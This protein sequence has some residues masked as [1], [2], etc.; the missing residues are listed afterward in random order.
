MPQSAPVRF[1]AWATW[2]A[3]DPA[4]W[5]PRGYVV[6]NADLRGWGAS[7]G[8]GELLNMRQEGE[9]CH[10]LIEWAARQPWSNGRV[11][12][13]GVSYLAISQWSAAATRP[14]H[15]AA[16]CP[17]EGFTDT[18]R[19]FA[20]PG[21][22]R[23][24]GFVVIWTRMAKLRARNR[25]QATADLRDQQLARPE[26]DDWWASRA[27]DVD[28]IDA[29]A[30]VCGSFSDHNLHTDG[31]FRGF[32]RIG[33]AQKWLY[34]HRG[35]KWATFYSDDALTAQTRFFDHFLA[36]ADNG[37]TDQ[38]PVRLEVRADADTITAVRGEQQWPPAATR[39]Q[40]WHLDPGTGVLADAGPRRAGVSSFDTRRGRVTLVRRFTADTEVVGPM[41][42]RLVVEARECAD[43]YLFAGVRKLRDGRPVA[44]E[45]AYGFR[46]SLVT[47]GMR[48]AS[49]RHTEETAE[50][51]RPG[52]V[53]GLDIELHPSAT[54]F[55]AD[56]ELQL[57]IRGRWF[58]GRFPLTSQFPAYY[59]KSPRGRCLL[60]TGPDAAAYL[61]VPV[62]QG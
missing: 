16:I 14:P 56:E 59:E 55:R 58:Y 24:D 9:D 37:Q 29:P 15:L 44:F 28:K 46:G 34:T 35:P 18:Y 36:G 57:D 61:D 43:L 2:E 40:R 6:V 48:K 60:H 31:S 33:S 47:F 10:D 30:L 25:P 4:Y 13:L 53:V 38:P 49:H 20:R 52:E 23:E 54:L 51:L 11:G 19:D 42:L 21:G 5:V 8:A 32:Q 41:L 50:P 7:Q 45:S 17:W 26:Y 39:W 22:I 12:L 62:Q 1:S 3:P 27:A